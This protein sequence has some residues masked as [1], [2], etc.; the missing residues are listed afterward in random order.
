MKSEAGHGEVKSNWQRPNL[1]VGEIEE[2]IE[3]ICDS[4]RC[5]N[6]GKRRD[7]RSVEGENSAG[8]QRE[9]R[10]GNGLGPVWGEKQDVYAVGV[11]IRSLLE[12]PR[13]SSEAGLPK[14]WL[15]LADQCL[16]DNPDDRPGFDQLIEAMK[17]GRDAIPARKTSR[18]HSL[19]FFPLLAG[20][21]LVFLLVSALN[22]LFPGW[23]DRFIQ[24]EQPVVLIDET[25]AAKARVGKMEP[26]GLISQPSAPESVP[27]A[28]HHEASSVPLIG[29]GL[30]QSVEWA[31]ILYSM[32][33]SSAKKEIRLPDFGAEDDL[34]YASLFPLEAE[35]RL[36]E[37]GKSDR[38][39]WQTPEKTLEAEEQSFRVDAI[40][41]EMI[42][43]PDLSCWMITHPAILSR[44]RP[45][46]VVLSSLPEKC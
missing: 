28:S 15:T 33:N 44:E 14:A 34:D 3:A 31:A 27:I 30:R 36:P 38:V 41:M 7:G 16:A 29:Q 13:T 40:G 2:C 45:S 39:Y 42:W 5:L 10:D 18:P 17:E 20:A 21:A 37:I 26:I 12:K 25:G 32:A 19:G 46:G 8:L 1:E 11:I 23:T 9:S 4:F 43:I 24:S 35:L 22:G 6:Q